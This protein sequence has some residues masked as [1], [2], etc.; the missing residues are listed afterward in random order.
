MWN[1][2][3]GGAC[4][5]GLIRACGGQS[6]WRY[7]HQHFAW[8]L[9]WGPAGKFAGGS[10]EMGQRAMKCYHSRSICSGSLIS[11]V[12]PIAIS[13]HARAHAYAHA[14]APPP[15]AH[16][17][18]RRQGW[19]VF[20]RR[21]MPVCDGVMGLAVWQCWLW[22]AGIAGGHLDLDLAG[23]ALTSGCSWAAEC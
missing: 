13:M 12:R 23:S 18:L 2:L 4:A 9:V 20:A 19:G 8:S 7:A 22:C 6:R 15:C 21:C 14:H 11:A 3:H 1:H 10:L 16:M 5:V 17:R